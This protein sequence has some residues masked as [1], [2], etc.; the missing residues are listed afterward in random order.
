MQE[1]IKL[2]ERNMDYKMVS[3]ALLAGGHAVSLN[4]YNA[5]HINV[6]NFI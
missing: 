5:K 1:G 3:A 2:T 6:P 4:V